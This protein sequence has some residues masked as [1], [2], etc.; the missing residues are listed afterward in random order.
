MRRLR[1]LTLAA[2][3]KG[4]DD[5]ERIVIAVGK[6]LTYCTDEQYEIVGKD[7]AIL[8]RFGRLGIGYGYEDEEFDDGDVRP[9]T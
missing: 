7:A 2:L 4:G 5:R 6:M 8:E 3:E 9:N 1:E